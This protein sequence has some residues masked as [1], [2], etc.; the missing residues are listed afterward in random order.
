MDQEQKVTLEEV[1]QIFTADRFGT[2]AAG[3]VVTDFGERYAKCEMEIKP[4]HLNASGR[5]M[6]GVPFTLADFAVAVAAQGYRKTL[7]TV[8]LESEISYFAAAKGKRLIAEAIC[9]K[10]GRTTSYYEVMIT[11]DLGTKVAKFTCNMF[12]LH[13]RGEEKE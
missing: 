4:V 5:V 12:T 8:S 11:D 9:I 7:D 3:A 13:P 1:Q 10:A 2:E 6:G